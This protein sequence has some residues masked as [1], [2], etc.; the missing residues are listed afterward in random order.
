[1]VKLMPGGLFSDYV[2]Q[3]LKPEQRLTVQGPYGNFH[4]RDTHKEALFVAGGSGMAPILSLLR[5]MAEK[6]SERPA[7]YFYGARARR[8]LFQV[9]E[10][11]AL[12]HQLPHFHFVLALS[13]SAPDDAWDGEV[14]LITDVVKRLISNGAGKEAYM[15]GPTAMIDAAIITLT[16]LGV[17]ES[18]IFYDKFVTK[19]DTGP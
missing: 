10:L 9:G 8:D 12:E 4:L 5:D 2:V 19:A 13:E 1:M 17:N 15:C 16:R 3:Q 6:R 18:D 7:T 11:R 14:G